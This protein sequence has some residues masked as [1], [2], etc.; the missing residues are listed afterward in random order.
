MEAITAKGRAL[1]HATAASMRVHYIGPSLP[2]PTQNIHSI[3][4]HFNMDRTK[5]MFEMTAIS[6]MMTGTDSELCVLSFGV[7]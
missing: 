2:L 4:Q 7:G 3:V 1:K 6:W 5:H